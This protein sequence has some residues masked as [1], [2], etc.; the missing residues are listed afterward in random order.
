MPQKE[1]ELI[2]ARQLASY[3]A[4]P[5]FLVDPQGALLYYNESAEAILG[6]R[7]DET[8]EV[9]LEDWTTAFIPR[10]QEGARLAPEELPLVIALKERRPAHRRFYIRGLD[11][12]LREIEVSALPILG[13]AGRYL[14]A[15]AMF[16][17]VHHAG[18][19]VG[20]AGVSTHSGS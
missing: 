1:V 13:Q 12:V 9:P 2:L 17:E 7:F 15:M 6:K 10:D 16:W 5:I 18:D 20:D 8:G 14:G 3:L 11:G 4:V 19:A